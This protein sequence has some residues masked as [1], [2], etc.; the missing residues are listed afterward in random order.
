MTESKTRSRGPSQDL[1]RPP[2]RGSRI[3]ATAAGACL[4]GVSLLAA[5]CG[6]A[7]ATATAS[8]PTGTVVVFAAASLKDAFD[9]I[10][11]Q[12]EKANPGVS[13]KFNYAGSSSLATQIKQGAPADV[14]ASADTNSMDTVTSAGGADGTA[15]TFAKNRMEIIVAPGNPKHITSVADLV[16]PGVQVVVCASAVPCGRYAQQI[17]KKANVTVKPVSEETSVSSVVTKITLGQADA[18]IVY[19]TDVRAAGS[20]AEGVKIPDN[21]NVL[22][23]YPIVKVKGAP[24]GDGA[25]AFIDYVMSPAGQKVLASFGFLPPGT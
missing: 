11:T 20:K 6:T 25:S 10:G 7:A 18:G 2:R 8:K 4:A 1:W 3:R 14:F 23:D 21:L 12:F 15:Q 19:T 13:M 17:F 9:E 22:A 5:G 24:N 16:K